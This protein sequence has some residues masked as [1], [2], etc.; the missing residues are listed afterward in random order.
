MRFLDEFSP[1]SYEL[2]I[3]YI[4]GP[5]TGS[6]SLMLTREGSWQ[7]LGVSCGRPESLS[8]PHRRHDGTIRF[9][10]SSPK[11]SR[12]SMHVADLKP[13][14]LYYLAW[15][16]FILLLHLKGECE[17][18][19]V[20]VETT[21]LVVIGGYLKRFGTFIRSDIAGTQNT[22]TMEPSSLVCTILPVCAVWRHL[23]YRYRHNCC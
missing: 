9:L 5:S 12:Q 10:T 22:C 4:R 6:S 3:C 11:H 7:P 20:A 2:V 1:E 8:S 23:V 14:R 13:C 17:W 21:L 15:Q 18:R 16:R 19:L